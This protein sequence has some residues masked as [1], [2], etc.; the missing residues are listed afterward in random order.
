MGNRVQLHGRPS[1]E[2]EIIALL[3]HKLLTA[4]VDGVTPRVGMIK[5]VNDLRMAGSAWKKISDLLIEWL[6]GSP[7]QENDRYR[8][9]P[10]I[11]T[12]CF[13]TALQA[14]P[15]PG[16]FL[17]LVHPVWLDITQASES[18]AR[19][20]HQALQKK[21]LIHLMGN[22]RVAPRDALS[23]QTLANQSA[24]DTIAKDR[25][26]QVDLIPSSLWI[27][28]TVC[29][30]SDASNRLSII[31]PATKLRPES[32]IDSTLNST[33]VQL[34][35][36]TRA[37][38][39]SALTCPAN[40]TTIAERLQIS[41]PSAS[42]HT[43]ILRQAGLISSKRCGQSVRHCPTALGTRLIYSTDWHGSHRSSDD[44]MSPGGRI[45]KY[46]NRESQMAA[47]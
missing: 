15:L 21:G 31:Y 22:L 8:Y 37:A 10:H 40:T 6:D 18:S 38:I 30:P 17:S 34:I 36:A 2:L 35:G 3:L 19:Y 47:A 23:Y 32:Q 28:H 41:L 9:L 45:Y 14:G 43:T 27:F 1:A 25:S 46:L 4:Q 44:D 16:N 20:V 12:S 26:L 42:R 7:L 24:V 13:A 29:V 33:L 39:L 5:R 11:I